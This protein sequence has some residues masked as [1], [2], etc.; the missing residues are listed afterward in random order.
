MEA[1][2]LLIGD[3]VAILLSRW[4]RW[5]PLLLQC[6]ALAQWTFLFQQN[7]YG[8][9]S[10]SFGILRRSRAQNLLGFRGGGAGS[11]VP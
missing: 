2:L 1:S 6:L 5:W 7:G 4:L 3:D 9:G 8:S 11:G 10:S